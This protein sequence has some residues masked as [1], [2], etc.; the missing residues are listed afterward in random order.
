MSSKPT[1][2]QTVTA[3]LSSRDIA[4]IAHELRSPLGGFEAVLTMLAATPLTPEQGNLVAALE[5]STA[6][7][8]SILG[9]VLPAHQGE[10]VVAL[11]LGALVRAIATSA[12][13]RAK[14]RGLDFSVRLDPA[15]DADLSLD[16]LALRQVLENLIDN[17]IRATTHGHIDLDIR[18]GGADRIVFSLR[19]TGPGLPEAVVSRLSQPEAPGEPSEGGMGL[20]IAMRLIGRKGGRLHAGPNPGGQGTCLS[21]DWPIGPSEPA[22]EQARFLIVDDH[23]ASRLVLRTIL[24]A[25]GFATLEAANAHEAL[26]LLARHPV[27]VIWSDLCMPDGDGKELVRA[28]AALA[29]DRRPRLVIVS[30]DDPREDVA[31]ASLID[32][33][34]MKPISVPAIVR[35]LDAMGD[36]A[37]R[38]A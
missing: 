32:D 13:A 12:Q 22:T 10:G 30:A 1:P 17:A 28:I 20:S 16:A 11:R 3:A 36:V 7:L 29:P 18:A 21:F 9:R 15:L 19:D 2:S 34:V 24:N 26:A 37:R 35:A 25:L 27:S 14:A 38:A 8:R 33:V 23:P 5:A 31:M 6:H 4:E